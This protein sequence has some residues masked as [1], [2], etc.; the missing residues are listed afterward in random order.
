MMPTA[1]DEVF[2]PLCQ[3]VLD[4]HLAWRL[5]RQAFA[6]SEEIVILL[7]SYAGVWFGYAQV[8]MYDDIVVSLFRLLDPANQ[9][10]G[11]NN[12]TLA[13]L[14]DV[15]KADNQIA[16]AALIRSARNH[17][18]NLLQPFADWR[19]KRVAHNDLSRMQAVWQGNPTTL[20]PSRQI[21]EESLAGVRASMDSVDRHYQN[22]TTAY[23]EICF[24]LG[25]D[26]E[27]LIKH[28]KRYTQY[29]EEDRAGAPTPGLRRNW[30]FVPPDAR[31]ML[32][33]AHGQ[34]QAN[35]EEGAAEDRQGR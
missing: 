16:L 31:H 9:G 10:N 8:A 12:L 34:Q 32:R 23:A 25:Q 7:N 5:Y 17:V 33:H 2:Q 24:P 14:A 27:E 6:N 20:G 21:I 30:P 1:I 13:R 3:E 28:L 4:I 18:E 11:R 15:V 19:N 35:S 26:G 29:L 22:N